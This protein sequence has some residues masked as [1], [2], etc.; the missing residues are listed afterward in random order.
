MRYSLIKTATLLSL[1]CALL[2]CGGGDSPASVDSEPSFTIEINPARAWYRPGQSLTFRGMEAAAGVVDAG[3]PEVALTWTFE[4]AGAFAESPPVEATSE[5]TATLATEGEVR[6]QGCLGQGDASECESVRIIVDEGAPM[7][8][9]DS[10][11]AGAASSDPEGIAVSGQ[12][13]DSRM[14][15]VFVNGSA[16]ELSADGRFVTR[17][18]STFGVHHVEVVATDGLGL[19]ARVERDALWAPSFDPGLDTDGEPLH[20][21]DDAIGVSLDRRFF[22]DG[23]ALERGAVPVVTRDVADILELVLYAAELDRYV[24]SPLLEEGGD[25]TVSLTDIR[26]ESADIEVGL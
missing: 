23:S 13:M 19:E 11:V 16:V 18:Q 22:D 25:L 1:A 9:V 26:V 21:L 3:G 12:V 8:V 20:R 15:R 4:P 14:S 17:L 6:V 24:P 5:L 2:A 7:L 10:P